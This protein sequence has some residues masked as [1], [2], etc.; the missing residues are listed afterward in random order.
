M[1][2]HTT[3]RLL[4]PPTKRLITAS[5]Y[6]QVFKRGKKQ[7]AEFFTFIYCAN[8]FS[9]ARLGLAIAKRYIPLAVERNRVRRIIRESFRQYQISM[10]AFDIVV[11]AQKALHDIESASLREELNRVWQRF[12]T[13]PNK[14]Y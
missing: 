10:K 3:P 11:I 13:S 8:D 1:L 4:F 6:Q 9:F 7:R 12:C 2:A 14:S 5:G